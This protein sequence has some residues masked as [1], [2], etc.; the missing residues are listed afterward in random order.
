MSGTGGFFLGAFVTLLLV[1]FI[2]ALWHF[3][4]RKHFFPGGVAKRPAVGLSNLEH[5]GTPSSGVI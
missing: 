1:I 4:F 2:S 3:C 5:T